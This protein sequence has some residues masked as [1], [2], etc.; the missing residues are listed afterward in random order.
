MRSPRFRNSTSGT[1]LPEVL[2]AA[3]VVGVFF[4]SIFELNAVCLRYISA[5]KE[6]ITGIECVQDRIEQL[7]NLDFTSLTSESALTTLMSLPANSSALASM[8]TETVTISTFSGSAATSPALTL[9]RGPGASIGVSPA[10]NVTVTPTK[11]WSG[12]SSFGTA[13]IV[14]VDVTYSWKAIFGRR[15]RSERSSTIISAGLKK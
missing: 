11:Q 8:A 9:A 14:Q 7:R 13:S 4:A 3:V 2:T 12:S 10:P 5:S 15:A 1:T 6:N